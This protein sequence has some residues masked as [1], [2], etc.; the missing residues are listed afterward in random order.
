MAGGAPGT[1]VRCAECGQEARI[2]TGATSVRSKPVSAPVPASLPPPSGTR[3]PG[4]SPRLTRV[5]TRSASGLPAG[6]A[7]PKFNSGLFVG[8]GIGALGVGVVILIMMTRGQHE[9]PTGTSPPPERRSASPS[10]NLSAPPMVNRPPPSVDRRP[11]PNPGGSPP[12]AENP[13]RVNWNQIMEALRPGGGFDH[14]DRPEGVAFRRV[15]SFGKAAY[16]HLIG[17]ITDEDGAIAIAAV[18]VLNV[19]T[20]RDSP[21]PRGVSKAK[22]KAE[23]E[24]WLKNG[25]ESPKTSAVQADPP[26][27]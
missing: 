2:P 24:E 5:R 1:S 9:E 27:P 15:K 17:Y 10:P 11:E 13:D 8:L 26:K 18:V 21:L 22:V 19:L 20:G 16:P 12:Q 23:W 14:E 6:L 7:T 3:D 25:S 4:I